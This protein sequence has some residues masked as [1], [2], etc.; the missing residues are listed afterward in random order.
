HHG[1]QHGPQGTEDGLPVSD[2]DVTPDQEI[3]ELAITPDLPPVEAGPAGRRL[4][5]PPRLSWQGASC[6]L[7]PPFRQ[8]NDLLHRVYQDDRLTGS[9]ALTV[10]ALPGATPRGYGPLRL[11]VGRLSSCGLIASAPGLRP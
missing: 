10:S 2:A 7:R 9:R 11:G 4:D 6:F 8:L 3:E 5:Q 1:L